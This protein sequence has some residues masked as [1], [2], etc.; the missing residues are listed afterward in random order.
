MAVKIAYFYAGASKS[1]P[2]PA[3]TELKVLWSRHRLFPLSFTT[4]IKI[5]I[6]RCL[7]TFEMREIY[8]VWKLFE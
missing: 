6:A 5:P 3:V 2:R 1:R 8:G 4:I 7:C